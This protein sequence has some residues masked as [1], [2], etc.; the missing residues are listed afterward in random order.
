[1]ARLRQ[2]NPGNYRSSDRIGQEFESVIRYINAAEIGDKTIGELMAILF[3]A[4]GEFAGPIEMRLN[5]TTGLEFRVGTY[6]NVEDGWQL[7]S[8]IS[9]LRGA[10]GRDVGL[11]PTPLFSGRQDFT[12]TAGQTEFSYTPF[13]EDDDLLVWVTGGLKTEG[14]LNDYVKDVLAQTVTF[15]APMA[16][17]ESVTIARIRT[18]IVQN[19]RREDF[20]AVASQVVFPFVHDDTQTLMIFRNGILQ[21]LGGTYDYT[22]D[23]AT[24][25]VS[26]MTPLSAGDVVSIITVDDTSQANVTGLMLE[27]NYTSN[28]LILWS[29]IAVD[30]GAIPAAKVNGLTNLLE[31]RGRVFLG[32]SSPASPVA[33]DLWLDTSSNPNVLK[34]YSG[35]EWVNTSPNIN[36]P[37]YS[38][39]NASWYLRVNSAGNGLEWATLDL[40]SRVPTSWVGAANG[41]ASL[42]SGGFL[43]ISQ[44]PDTFSLGSEYKVVSGSVT[45]TDVTVKRIFKQKLRIDA[46]AVKCGAGSCSI[47]LKVAGVN[48]GDVIAVGTTLVEQNLSASIE[49]DAISA[50]KTIAFT[51][52]GA[53]SCSDLEV[54]LATSAVTA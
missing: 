37:S 12:A 53:T 13:T 49:V 18:D 30:D 22:N 2:I 5:T 33:T 48:V 23:P 43:P 44:L 21:R 1:M 7:V 6:A 11:V 32:S 14:A 10:P 27:D 40:T 25:T 4:N 17:G 41:V 45:N 54:T 39:T 51:I 28:G 26:F 8:S 34:V 16:G 19:Y 50:S 3:D 38:N 35:V 42:D 15:N 20:V 46:V 9:D 24:D 29:K 36:I 52:T 31:N 47:Q